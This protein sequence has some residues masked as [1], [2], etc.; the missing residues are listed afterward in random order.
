MRGKC[1]KHRRQLSPARLFNMTINKDSSSSCDHRTLRRIWLASTQKLSHLK[2]HR[3]ISVCAIPSTHSCAGHD[4][5]SDHTVSPVMHEHD[6]ACCHF[7]RPSVPVEYIT[8]LKFP[9]TVTNEYYT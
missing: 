5:T 2:A 6:D 7:W 1:G 9:T 4:N 8:N 3:E